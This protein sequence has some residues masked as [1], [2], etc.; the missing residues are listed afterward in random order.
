MKD[1]GLGR[2]YE[3]VWVEDFWVGAYIFVSRDT[4]DERIVSLKVIGDVGSAKGTKGEVNAH[5]TLKNSRIGRWKVSLV[6][7]IT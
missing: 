2:V 7:V 4:P 3:A 6:G 1:F 5:Q